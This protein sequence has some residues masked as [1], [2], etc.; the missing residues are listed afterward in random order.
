MAPTSGTTKQ[1][2]NPAGE[3]SS[4]ETMCMLNAAMSNLARASTLKEVLAVTLSTLRHLYKSEVISVQEFNEEDKTWSV[5]ELFSSNPQFL[6]QFDCLKELQATAKTKLEQGFPLVVDDLGPFLP[7]PKSK[8]PQLQFLLA[9]PLLGKNKIRGGIIMAGYS[10]S[11]IPQQGCIL[12][13]LG[14]YIGNVIGNAQLFHMVEHAKKEWEETFDSISD[15]VAIIDRDC[16]IIRANKALA[17]KL[18]KHPRQ[19]VGEKCY[20]LLHCQD[21]PVADCPHMKTL[22]SKQPA[23][24]EIAYFSNRIIHQVTTSPIFGKQGEVVATAHIAHDISE[25]K[26]LEE[27]VLQMQKMDSLGALAGGIAHDFNNLLEGV[28]GYA[29]YLTKNIARDNPIY[30]D[31]K[32]IEDSAEQAGNLS[33]QLLTFARKGD[34]QSQPVDLN[35]VV[36]TVLKL[37]SRTLDK[38]IAI[39]QSCTE[40]EAIIEGDAGQLEQTLLNLCLNARDAMPNGGKLSIETQVV[41][42]DRYFARYHLGIQP[43]HFTLLAVTDTGVGM[44]KATKGKIFEP[45]FSTK[46]AD[47]GSGLGL[48]MVY[49]IIKNHKGYI[50]VYSEK[51]KGSVFKVYLPLSDQKAVV[52]PREAVKIDSLRGNETILVVDDEDSIRKLLN[53]LLSQNG[54]KVLL[55]EDGQ[56]AVDIFQEHKEEIDLVILDMITPRMNGREVYNLLKGFRADVR[57]ILCSGYSPDSQIQEL[58]DTAQGFVQKPY[59]VD[60]LLSKVREALG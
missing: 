43:G 54:Y 28:L 31:L 40:E 23:S 21:E 46:Q 58:L 45:F 26:K 56:Q 32:V 13:L 47:K 48:A 12:L 41:Y 51:G 53:K 7:S 11:L 59:R 15:L 24:G 55:A 3:N 14:N 4:E 52:V 36:E 57:V 22:Q 38:N 2:A 17:R 33:K 8:S 16:R 9:L 35:Q 34:R 27:Q 6:A 10:P 20:E 18:K 60:E 39:H 49:G 50:N 37:L 19:I 29:S 42:L 30:E 1:A 44:S 25:H 5:L